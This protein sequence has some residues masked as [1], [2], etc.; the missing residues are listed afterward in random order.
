MTLENDH[1]PKQNPDEQ[2]DRDPSQERNEKPHF[3]KPTPL[4]AHVEEQ[5][6]R[7]QFIGMQTI[8][9]I[10]RILDRVEME[11][12]QDDGKQDRYLQ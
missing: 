7:L 2:D 6:N 12:D 4:A 9:T 1:N 5:L 8:A 11:D 3:E 10:Q